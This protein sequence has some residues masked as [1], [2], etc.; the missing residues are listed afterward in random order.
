MKKIYL[1]FAVC[2]GLFAKAQNIK[3]EGILKDNKG[4]P[5]ETANVIAINQATKAMD[6]Y[7]ITS[8]KGKFILN[9]KPN[10]AYT[11]KASYLGFAPFEKNITTTAQAIQNLEISLSEDNKIDDI[12]IVRKMPVTIKG[13]TII[14]DADS[15][16]NGT[17][18]KLEDLIKKMPG[19]EI[20]KDGEVLVEGKVVNKLMVDGK[21]FFDGDTKLGT[22]NIP[23]NAVDKLQVLRNYNEVSNL[24]GL[25]NNQDDLAINIKLKEGKK[26]FWFGDVLA[27]A[28][29][30]DTEDRHIVNPKL[31]YYSP[32][33]SINIIANLNNIG[34]QTLSVQD[35]FK[36]TGGFK[37]LARNNGSS[38]SVSSNQLGITGLRNDRAQNID[39]KFGAANFSYNPTKAFSISGFGIFSYNKTNTLQESLYQRNDRL[40]NGN[41][42]TVIENRSDANEQKTNLGL[43]KLSASYVPN[44]KKH[45]D[46]DILVRASD[47]SENQSVF[48][49]LQ[50]DLFTNKN[51][52]PI[53]VNQNFNYY[54]TANDKNIFGFQ[55]QNL[56]Q[57]EDP[58]YNANLLFQP[59]VLVG[60]NNTQNRNNIVQDRFTKTNKTDAKLDYYYVINP[61][62]NF[63]VTLGNIYSYQNFDSS[64]FQILDNGT[65]NN[66]TDVSNTNR[67]NFIF[68]DAFLG[69]H[70]KILW[71]KFTFNPGVS[72]HQ[73]SLND[74]QNGSTNKNQFTRLLPDF[75]AIYQIKKSQSLT[76]NYRMANNFTD[77][78]RLAEGAVF[79]S[80]SS[81]F[82]GNRNLENAIAHTHRI[83][84]SKFT[85]FNMEN[86]NIS[87]S[88]NKQINTI[89]NRAL[90]TGINQQSTSV[91]MPSNFPNQTFSGNIFYSRAFARY[92]KGD[93]S[94]SYSWNQNNNIRV[95]PGNIEVFQTTENK[96]QNYFLKLNTNL[97]NSPNM[98][99][100]YDF[101]LSD[102]QSQI[103]YVDNPSFSIEYLF[104]N[105]F[106]FRSSY[107]YFHNRSK[108]KSIDTEYDLLSASLSYKKK[109]S[110]W[111]YI[112]NATNL[113]NSTTQN[114]SSFNAL[115]GSSSFTTYFIQPRFVTFQV[116][117]NL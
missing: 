87:A 82:S 64:I 21:D 37:N 41:N 49:S 4:N 18:R 109:D 88:Y 25:E 105:A 36:F 96:T 31:F 71:G 16:S 80:Y 5:L 55:V 9:L 100:K 57:E 54:Y 62:S 51:Q 11:I 8:D 1:L 26:N 85:M 58:F 56:Y 90:L 84:Y 106:S 13:D 99:I 43:F 98:E 102:L 44:T 113:L 81:L 14:Y 69:L 53:S 76:Y 30:G 60:Y 12:E 23:A 103:F 17:E 68:N 73:F 79:N 33:N 107:N 92:F 89:T 115:G 3:L 28:G 48:S 67:V 114:D 22:K 39:A 15:F 86:I 52:K 108:D 112:I 59:F 24:K 27:G 42:L 32:K 97:K 47:Q 63:N 61:K 72:L 6:S 29:V 94:A 77:I 117:Y 95:L 116:R 75:F 20:N 38:F 104:L 78:N 50:G 40:P 7:N 101:T 45:A 91:N 66:L 70:Y 74:T 93:V 46:Y 65:N 111:E 34:E 35:Y 2:I 19:M 110:K 83:A 10:T